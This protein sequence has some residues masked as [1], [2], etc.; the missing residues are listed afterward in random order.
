MKTCRVLYLSD[1]PERIQVWW[2]FSLRTWIHTIWRGICNICLL[3]MWHEFMCGMIHVCRRG[4]CDRYAYGRVHPRVSH[5]SFINYM[6]YSLVHVFTCDMNSYVARF[7]CAG[8]EHMTGM[9]MGEYTHTWDMTHSINYMIYSHVH[10]WRDSHVQERHMRQMWHM[11]PISYGRVHTHM[12]HDSLLSITWLIPMCTCDMSFSCRRGSCHTCTWESIMSHVHMGINPVI[13]RNESCL[14]CVCTLPYESGEA[15]ERYATHELG[16]ADYDSCVTWVWH[17]LMSH[18]N[19]ESGEADY[20]S[21]LMYVW[22]D[23][24]VCYITHACVTWLMHVWHDSCM[25]DM[26]HACATWLMRV[27]HD[28]CMCY[29][30][31]SRATW[32]NTAHARRDM[33]SK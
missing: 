29:M 24:C 14:M 19:H 16:E 15:E 27:W 10:V 25:C 17:L 4:T 18:M 5:D 20:N 32:L 2:N 3:H 26:T 33:A 31:H 7:T 9:H 28:S 1:S 11:S 30:P 23:S 6:I 22:R 21:W 12:R 8:E 13:D